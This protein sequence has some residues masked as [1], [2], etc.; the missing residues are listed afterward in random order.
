MS[1]DP[2]HFSHLVNLVICNP[3]TILPHISSLTAMGSQTAQ[4]FGFLPPRCSLWRFRQ[5]YGH[6]NTSE[7]PTR[8]QGAESAVWFRWKLGRL[9]TKWPGFIKAHGAFVDHAQGLTIRKK[10]CL[11]V[12][13][14]M[15]RENS[16]CFLSSHPTILE[17][18]CGD[19]KMENCLLEM[20]AT[21][22]FNQSHPLSFQDS[23]M[24]LFLKLPYLARTTNTSGLINQNHWPKKGD[25]PFISSSSKGGTSTWVP[26]QVPTFCIASGKDL[27]MDIT[28]P[29]DFIWVPKVRSTVGNLSISQ[30]GIFTT[31]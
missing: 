30:R 5:R 9:E 17:R 23:T 24:I 26:S 6:V 27:A 4:H 25:V 29:T 11:F 18:L 3:P 22:H 21:S 2:Y 12:C 10:V 20:Y 7:T 13:L 16:P 31:Q 28:S 8:I 15:G 1:I 14:L 19:G